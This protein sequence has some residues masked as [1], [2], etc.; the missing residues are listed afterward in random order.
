MKSL[1]LTT[2]L[3]AGGLFLVSSAHAADDNCKDMARD[4]TMTAWKEVLTD[5]TASQRSDL[6]ELALTI[7]ER[8]VEKAT[9][10]ADNNDGGSEDWFS[11]RVLNG[12]PADKP[13]N[14]RLERRRR[15]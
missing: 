9:T 8:H 15:Q 13:G 6:Q 5:M 3:F 4:L 2:L 14:K 7:C 10:T 12:E 1:S 11:D